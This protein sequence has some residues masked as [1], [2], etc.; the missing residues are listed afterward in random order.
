MQGPPPGF[1]APQ[2]SNGTA[3]LG[4]P[5]HSGS[6]SSAATQHD[7]QAQHWPAS[8][9]GQQHWLSFHQSHSSP[10]AASTQH[11][12]SRL[13][14]AGSA[15]PPSYHSD[16]F[17]MPGLSNL[18]NMRQQ[19]SSDHSLFS[20]SSNPP[21]FPQSQFRQ[22]S[23]FHFAQ[24]QSAALGPDPA[25]PLLFSSLVSPGP[26]QH[27]SPFQYGHD[28][29]QHHRQQSDRHLFPLGSDLA[30][31]SLFSGHPG[32][33]SSGSVPTHQRSMH[34]ATSLH[35]ADVDTGIS[36]GMIGQSGLM[37]AVCIHVHATSLPHSRHAHTAHS[38]R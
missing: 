32:M 14:Q 6:D 23:R 3:P 31:A 13:H 16:A 25:S 11:S 20:G 19:A 36:G 28:H 22:R 29:A 4:L 1:G 2:S 38:Q 27:S 15:G 12:P 26:Q 21:G 34:L 8:Q 10:Q 35:E 33:P 30:G 37:P 5:S 9:E 7:Q 17:A 18:Q 24:D